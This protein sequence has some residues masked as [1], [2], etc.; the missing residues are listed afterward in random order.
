V[1]WTNG[2]TGTGSFGFVTNGFGLPTSYS[3][4]GIA[5]AD[6]DGD[7]LPDWIYTEYDLNSVEIFRNASTPQSVLFGEGNAYYTGNDPY[8]HKCQS[9]L[10]TLD[11]GL[12]I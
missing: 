10:L 11:F 2:S 4:V 1:I 5:T 12:E 3:P 9:Q 8:E 7:G 6:L